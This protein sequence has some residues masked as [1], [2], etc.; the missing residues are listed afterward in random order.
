M[1]FAV[2]N[3]GLFWF[4]SWGNDDERGKRSLRSSGDSSTPDGGGHAADDGGE[5]TSVL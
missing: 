5:K 3:K 1:P 4:W 2:H